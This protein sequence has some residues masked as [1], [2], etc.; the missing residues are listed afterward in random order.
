V[1]RRFAT[2]VAS[3]GLALAFAL[4]GCVSTSMSAAEVRVP[5]LLG[6]VPCLGCAADTRVP[7]ALLV[8]RVSA[9]ARS[10]GV[11]IPV[12][13]G[14]GWGDASDVGISADRLLF[15]TPCDDDVRLS[16]LSAHAWQ[17]TVP[18]FYF[19]YDLSV[20]AETS[21][22]KVPGASCPAP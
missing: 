9:E 20:Q 21:T 22:L 17:V 3:V 7:P 10:F 12:G 14:V 19:F 16:N 11:F 6:P 1:T 15:G 13:Q 8:S 2:A 18:I 5:V 4:G